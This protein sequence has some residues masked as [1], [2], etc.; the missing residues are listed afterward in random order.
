MTADEKVAYDS[1]KRIQVFG[2]E[3]PKDWTPVPPAA[4]TPAQ[5]NTSALYAQLDGVLSE[6]TQ[7]GAETEAA[8]AGFH[9]GT[10]SK[11]LLRAGLL[12]ELKS[13]NETAGTIAEKTQNPALMAK[14]RM[15]HGNGDKELADKARAMADA[16]EAMATDFVAL[17]HAADFA[18][19]LRQQVTTFEGAKDDQSGGQ[20]DQ[21]KGN[22]RISALIAQGVLISK[23]LQRLMANLYK[24]NAAMLGAWQTACH[25]EHV[26][27]KA[28]AAKP[29]P[30]PAK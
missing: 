28:K 23:Q 12:A 11:Q 29:Q 17:G 4:P 6:L 19:A 7:A 15:P 25:I 18:E 10:S 16:G 9:S 20:Q 13:V 30:A 24:G 21:V 5:A 27:H 3:Y 2:G 14:F 22:A 8:A 26:S 1:L